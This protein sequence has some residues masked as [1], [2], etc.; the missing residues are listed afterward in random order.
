MVKLEMEVRGTRLMMSASFCKPG[1]RRHFILSSSGHLTDWLLN[2]M[3]LDCA[4]LLFMCIGWTVHGKSSRLPALLDIANV[5]I[6][7]G[8]KGLLESRMRF[9]H[10]SKHHFI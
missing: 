8:M 6:V 3:I 4:L 2:Y 9:L 7:S 1:T 10:L 5:D